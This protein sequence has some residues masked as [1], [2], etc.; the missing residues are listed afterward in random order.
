MTDYEAINHYI[1]DMP[2]W[3]TPAKCQVL[4][5]C[6]IESAAAISVDLGAFGGRAS[7][8]MAFAHRYMKL[9]ACHAV[10]AWDHD[11]CLEGIKDETNRAW[12]SKPGTP[13]KVGD[14]DLEKIHQGFLALIEGPA[15]HHVK[16]WVEVHCMRIE[17]AYKLFLDGTVG[18]LH[19]DGNHSEFESA[20]DIALWMPKMAPG[21]FI[22]FDDTD[23]TEEGVNTTA[24]AQ[25]MLTDA[26]YTMTHKEPKCDSA[27]EW[28]IFKGPDAIYGTHINEVVYGDPTIKTRP[29]FVVVESTP[30]VVGDTT[31]AEIH[32]DP[33]AKE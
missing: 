19:F 17:E 29:G 7:L 5:G 11:V 6:V 16:P 9:G 4:Y 2:G 26:G 32:H 12:W 23:W 10:D 8:A 18:V 31:P 21:G 33:E 28:A 22:C 3:S 25:K 13:G 20:R 24:K 1:P 15:S 14:L 27:G 30:E